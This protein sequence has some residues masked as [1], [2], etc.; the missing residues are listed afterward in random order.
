MFALIPGPLKEVDNE[1]EMDGERTVT[2]E[3]LKVEVPADEA[4]RVRDLFYNAF[5]KEEV[6][7][8]QY[9]ITQ[10]MQFVPRRATQNLGRA[11]LC[12]YGMKQ[13]QWCTG[14]EHHTVRRVKNIDKELEGKDGSR[15]T[16]RKVL[17][18][19]RD[20]EGDMLF[21]MVER[22]SYRRLWLIYETKYRAVVSHL[23]RNLS[24]L[25]D[26]KFTAESA[27]LLREEDAHNNA[28]YSGEL[29]PSPPSANEFERKLK[30]KIK[31]TAPT[32]DLR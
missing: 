10:H 31:E 12:E 22:A 8:E 30:E 1:T 13:N 4:D 24:S 19:T 29:P 18:K 17:M 2:F 11:L 14:I 15:T 21:R 28:I 23:V 20:A 7:L 27:V 32:T 3:S 16:L 26:Q 5:S 9:P 6:E 25:V